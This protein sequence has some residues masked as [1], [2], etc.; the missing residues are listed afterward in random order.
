MLIQI[1]SCNGCDVSN[2]TF[3]APANGIV[4]I[5]RV[6]SGGD[7]RDLTIKD[8]LFDDST[9]SAIGSI[10]TV[11]KGGNVYKQEIAVENNIAKTCLLGSDQESLIRV[12]LM[13][14]TTAGSE[15]DGIVHIA[16][17]MITRVLYNSSLYLLYDYYEPNCNI[18]IARDANHSYGVFF[19]SG[20]TVNAKRGKIN[21]VSTS[22]STLSLS[23][24]GITVLPDLNSLLGRNVTFSGMPAA[25]T[26]Y[27]QNGQP[28]WS[29]GTNWVDATGTTV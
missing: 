26:M 23:V 22:E 24:S 29:D 16:D 2:N 17:N 21:V 3:I 9:T 15:Y 5:L 12:S 11:T 10:I 14:D 27:W 8:N 6:T 20:S 18:D 4:D 28:T 1:A 13:K 25:G 19:K 7:V